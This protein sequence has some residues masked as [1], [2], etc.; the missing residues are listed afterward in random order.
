MHGIEGAD[1]G[2]PAVFAT[3][4]VGKRKGVILPERPRLDYAATLICTNELWRAR[5]KYNNQ[6][7]QRNLHPMPLFPVLV[8]KC[9]R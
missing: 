2:P 3:M 7:A 1:P 8:T 4:H 9:T 5:R 6:K